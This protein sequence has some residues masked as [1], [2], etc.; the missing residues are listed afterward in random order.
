MRNL[1][2]TSTESPRLPFRVTSRHVCARMD[3]G[4]SSSIKT[5]GRC[6]MQQGRAVFCAHECSLGRQ[7]RS[8]SLPAQHASPCC[9]AR[10]RVCAGD[11]GLCCSC[12]THVCDSH[13]VH[14]AVANAGAPLQVESWIVASHAR[15]MQA[16]IPPPPCTPLPETPSMHGPAVKYCAQCCAAALPARSREQPAHAGPLHHHP[17][18]HSTLLSR[19]GSTAHLARCTP[20]ARR[21]RQPV[22]HAPITSYR[23]YA[24]QCVQSGTC[25]AGRGAAPALPRNGLSCPQRRLHAPALL[26]FHRLH[27]SR[28]WVLWLGDR[29]QDGLWRCLRRGL[30][31]GGV[32]GECT[33]P[34]RSTPL[35][36][37]RMGR[38]GACLAVR[39]WTLSTLC[40]RHAPRRPPSALSCPLPGSRHHPGRGLRPP[41][42]WPSLPRLWRRV[43]AGHGRTARDWRHTGGG[44]G[45][46][47]L[48]GGWTGQG[49]LRRCHFGSQRLH[50]PPPGR[51]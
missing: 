18:P 29:G 21:A 36:R 28:H 7:A 27:R 41:P 1:S 31:R 23:R 22:R 33:P 46:L 34:A 40:A 14:A 39:G 10:L 50:T 6:H 17:R 11:L 49:G 24:A 9:K 51:R 15:S 13:V 38:K 25:P 30:W 32:R 35:L 4:S 2:R 26:L 42:P 5:D 16:S 48:V 37:P 19:Q 45:A 47:G 12:F 43:G 3:Q 8:I 20:T 44:I